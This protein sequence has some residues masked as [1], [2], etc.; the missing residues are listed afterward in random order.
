MRKWAWVC[1]HAHEYVHCARTCRHIVCIPTCLCAHADPCMCVACT[2]IRACACVCAHQYPMPQSS[3]QGALQH[4]RP[5][6]AQTP[7]WRQSSQGLRGQ[8]AGGPGARAGGDTRPAH[9]QWPPVQAGAGT[10]TAR[11]P[12]GNSCTRVLGG[13][14]A[15]PDE[16]GS[17]PGSPEG[18]GCSWE[19]GPL[20]LELPHHVTGT[21]ASWPPSL[22]GRTQGWTS[23]MCPSGGPCARG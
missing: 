23:G 12:T 19:A 13:Q 2:H 9:G 17:T 21:H 5:G 1:K 10:R 18:Q 14:E 16:G 22:P 8:L 7:H 15:A 20:V 11:P 3:P 4:A 6:P